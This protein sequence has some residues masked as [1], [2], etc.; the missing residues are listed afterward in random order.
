MANLAKVYVGVDVSK[1][2]LDIYIHP[3]EQAFR[4]EN[5]TNAINQVKKRLSQYFVEQ[6]VCESSGGYEQIMLKIFAKHGYRTWQVDPKRIKAFIASEGVKF[7]TD[8]V[9]AR[10]IALFASQ[11]KCVYQKPI[12]SKEVLEL[13][14]LVK[15]R[16]ELVAMKADEKKR[17][18]QCDDQL[19]Q[20]SIKK[21]IETVEEEIGHLQEKIDTLTNNNKELKQKKN[22]MESVPGL[23]AITANV[24]LAFV[25]ELGSVTGKQAAALVGVAPYVNKS[26]TFIG[27]SFISGG[28][29]EPRHA[30]YMAAL[31]SS[32]SDKGFG[33]FY[34]KLV[35]R[36][37]LPKIALVAVMRKI[38]VCVNA[39]LKKGELWNP[40]FA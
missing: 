20:T 39:M 6:I 30:L 18:Q 16:R 9:D 15:R 2:Y 38:I 12:A 14:I 5:N 11:K 32:R 33:K 4:I 23:G 36:G 37:K 35:A 25:S 7:K 17:I 26:G 34:K 22:I 19:Y 21:I 29:A 24:L 10:M 27:K 40:V 3:V 13:Q 31:A 1:A 28:R 8:A